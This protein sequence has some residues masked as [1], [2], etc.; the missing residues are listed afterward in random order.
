MPKDRKRTK[1]S[2]VYSRRALHISDEGEVKFRNP[3]PLDSVEWVPP[4]T[5]T[6]NDY[7]PNHVFS[8]EMKLL[9]RSIVEDGWTQ[10]IVATPEG[11]IV[12]G[13]HRWTLASTDA[14]V[15]AL[16]GGLVPV[17]RTSPRDS[18]HARAS[19]V[20]HNRA[21]GQHAILKMGEIVRSMLDDGRSHEDV[22][23]DMGMEM[24][25]VERLADLRSSPERV[26]QDSFGRGWVPLPKRGE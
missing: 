26:G 5:L 19:T 21:R 12:D 10:P 20:R 6:A 3:Q 13:F 15:I 7:N 8:T 9:K 24:E 4:S 22:A 17:V 1:P 16:T 25:E 23:R 14:E 11:V 18:S 2:S